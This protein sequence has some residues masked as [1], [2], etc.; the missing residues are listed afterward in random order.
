MVAAI[1]AQL[2]SDQSLRGPAGRPG[3]PG[4]PG[5][6]G[7]AGSPG[8]GVQSINVSVDGDLIIEY[9]DGST[10]NAGKAVIDSSIPGLGGEGFSHFI[11]V[12][13]EGASYWSRME[14]E[15]A[16]AKERYSGIEVADP[17]SFAAKLPQLV[18][19]Q[20]GSPVYV[21]SGTR[22]VS[23]ALTAIARG[24]FDLLK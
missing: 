20:G 22:A 8:R 5:A 2:Q 21:V 17:P 12:R 16:R 7:P 3:Q 15:L 14:E 13:D 9:T 6:R 1:I 11:L 10:H 24:E 23:E 4:S 19:Y 18:G